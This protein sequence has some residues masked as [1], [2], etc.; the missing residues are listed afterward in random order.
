MDK[1]HGLCEPCPLCHQPR[2]F[3]ETN[4]TIVCLPCNGSRNATE[5]EIIEHKEAKQK[6]EWKKKI[7]KN[8]E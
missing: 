2:V 6:E 5:Q 8:E 3:N 1:A 7:L 4:N